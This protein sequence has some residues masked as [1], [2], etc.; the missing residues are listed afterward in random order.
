MDPIIIELPG[1]MTYLIIAMCVVEVVSVSAHV[2]DT[3]ATWRRGV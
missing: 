2:Y 3:L 1:W